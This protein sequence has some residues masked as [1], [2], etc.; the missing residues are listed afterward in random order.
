MAVS[1]VVVILVMSRALLVPPEVELQISVDIHMNFKIA[2]SSQEAGVARIANTSPKEALR[3]GRRVRRAVVG[4]ELTF[5]SVP[6]FLVEAA[7]RTKAAILVPT[8]MAVSL[9]KV[10]LVAITMELAGVVA[11]LEV[12][13]PTGRRVVEVPVTLLKGL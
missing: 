4:M 12:V 7:C 8:A 3:A 1:T 10:R 9:G 11:I 13:G 5:L 2:L 6:G